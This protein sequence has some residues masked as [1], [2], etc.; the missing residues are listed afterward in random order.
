[1]LANKSLKVECVYPTPKRHQHLTRRGRAFSCFAAAFC[2]IHL[3][4]LRG[5]CQDKPEKQLDLNQFV[6]NAVPLLEI[7]GVLKEKKKP[8]PAFRVADR[9]FATQTVVLTHK[10]EKGIWL[11]PG[12]FSKKFT[13]KFDYMVTIGTSSF[14]SRKA[15]LSHIKPRRETSVTNKYHQVTDFEAGN[16]AYVDFDALKGNKIDVGA[17]AYVV[18]QNYLLEVRVTNRN[19]AFVGETFDQIKFTTGES[20]RLVLLALEALKKHTGDDTPIQVSLSL[21]DDDP[22]FTIAD[23]AKLVIR[24]KNSG[25][26]S[27]SDCVVHCTPVGKFADKVDPVLF[28]PE[29]KSK[30]SAKITFDKNLNVNSQEKS[31]IAIRSGGIGSRQSS[32]DLAKQFHLDRKTWIYKNLVNCPK[33]SSKPA[34]ENSISLEK[35]I[36]VTVYGKRNGNRKS[37][38]LLDELKSVFHE[39]EKSGKPT[40]VKLQFPDLRKTVGLPPGSSKLELEYYRN[41]D[42]GEAYGG[43]VSVRALAIRAARYGDSWKTIDGSKEDPDFPDDPGAIVKNIAEFLTLAL[44]PKNAPAQMLSP[45]SNA[46]DIWRRQTG[47]GAKLPDSKMTNR[48]VGATY[49]CQEHAFLFGLMVRSLGFPARDVNV[50]TYKCYILADWQDASNEVWYDGT[51]QYWGLFDHEN[52][53]S[54]K[55]F[56]DPDKWYGTK[57]SY[58]VFR[59]CAPFDA[60]K[61]GVTS[62]FNIGESF[63]WELR[64]IAYKLTNSGA[65]TRHEKFNLQNGRLIPPG[66][67]I[68]Q[69][70]IHSPV[71][72]MVKLPDGKRFGLNAGIKESPD[73]WLSGS[74]SGLVNEI[75]GAVYVPE[76]V[77]RVFGNAK[78]RTDYQRILIPVDE[79]IDLNRIQLQLTAVGD[80]PYRIELFDTTEKGVQGYKD[81]SGTATKGKT[82]SWRLG[83]F[84]REGPRRNDLKATKDAARNG[85]TGISTQPIDS[86]IAKQLKIAPGV[87]VVVAHIAPGSPAAE[88]QIRHFDVITSISDQAVSSRGDF[89]R[90]VAGKRPGDKINLHV[91]RLGNVELILKNR[92]TRNLNVSKQEVR[93]VNGYNEVRT[94]VNAKWSEGYRLL[95]LA[96]KSNQLL[97]LLSQEH[98]DELQ[99]GAEYGNFE[100]LLGAF[101]DHQKAGWVLTSLANSSGEKWLAGFN[102]RKKSQVQKVSKYTSR[103]ALHDDIKA[104]W[105]ERFQL[106]SVATK[107]KQWLA[108]YTKESGLKK[109]SFIGYTGFEKVKTA[110]REKWKS[111][112]KITAVANAGDKWLVLFAENETVRQRWMKGSNQSVIKRFEE[113]SQQGYSAKFIASGPDADWFILF[114]KQK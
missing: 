35:A 80:G 27:V 9:T 66:K 102:K 1:M 67:K 60:E 113:Y 21:S 62:R 83:L 33:V 38:L 71:V 3:I 75:P 7:K 42:P 90:A 2:M 17:T 99:S 74:Q 95:S 16:L 63:T 77:T 5:V 43:D 39:V 10:Q 96:G 34:V 65:W 82:Q 105:K 101:Q 13:S 29:M 28:F 51:W 98:Q 88:T 36:R 22:Q 87:G 26:D 111:G 24:V 14:P 50:I 68:L 72:A 25:D 8:L 81:R 84:E 79:K 48:E 59:G 41:G 93:L 54:P 104:N 47:F 91:K 109:Q 19:P 45:R 70:N 46:E 61:A 4:Q 56:R 94:R 69:V 103:G 108:V 58:L 11:G 31:V 40:V 107:E 32:S 52:K 76:R 100:E 53:I 30:L 78:S 64:T 73:E 110:I 44:C 15:C 37:E 106:T 112:A 20:K 23:R 114:E 57:Y 89:I 6:Q 92:I 12:Q 18:H 49:V 86:L 55:P 97:Y 85:W